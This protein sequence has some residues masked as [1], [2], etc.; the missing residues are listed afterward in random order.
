MNTRKTRVAVLFGGRSTEHEISII[1]ALQVMDAIDSTRYDLLPV[2]VDTEGAWWTGDVLRQRSAY[3]LSN[4][5]RSQC[6]RLEMKAEPGSVLYPVVE[7]GGWFSRKEPAPIAVDVFV[8]AFHGTYGEDG[9][10]Q[11][12]LEWLGSAYIGCGVRAAATGMNKHASKQVAASVGVPVLDGVRLTLAMWDPSRSHELAETVL[13]SVPL[14]L[15]VKPGNLG[16]SIAISVARTMDE[17]MISLAGAFAF[18]SEVI[19]E[20]LLEPMYEL[21]VAVMMNG[22]GT[23]VAS[24][25]ERPRHEKH[26]LTFEDKYMKGEK[27]NKKT[28]MI[29]EGMASLQRDIHPADVDAS[30]LAQVRENAIA[31]YQAI[32]CRGVVRFDFLVDA[33]RNQAY[34]NEVNTFPG[35][36]S[37]YLWEQADPP[38]TFTEL[39]TELTEQALSEWRCKRVLQR[40]V[41]SRLF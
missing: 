10:I 28:G 14:P 38:Q 11:G 21:N 33:E 7:R 29:S 40:Q 20:P 37:Y 18:D 8:P 9:C 36:L 16:S 26:M 25:I 35:S 2:Y 24:A 6:T 31:I 27:G 3:P 32:D 23:P 5:A 17:L 13:A 22:E 30:V 34:F 12:V 1:T 19:V 15:I 41:T 39:L 4:D